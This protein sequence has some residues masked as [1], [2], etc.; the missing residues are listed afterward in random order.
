MQRDK[1]LSG[2]CP[3]T[4]AGYSR[5]QSCPENPTA[6]PGASYG[7]VADRG[8]QVRTFVFDFI[9]FYRVHGSG[10]TDQGATRCDRFLRHDLGHDPGRSKKRRQCYLDRRWHDTNDGAFA[11][12]NLHD[13]RICD[14][15]ATRRVCHCMSPATFL[16]RANG[17]NF[18]QSF[19]GIS[20]ER[21]RY[22]A[23]CRDEERAHLHDTL[24]LSY[25]RWRTS[26]RAS[27]AGSLER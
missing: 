5:E 14:A 15:S 2:C 11:H 12:F 20:D 18:I 22:S 16:R 23:D 9:Q 10:G 21:H 26:S 6:I 25:G 1:L 17:W 8:N 13:A 19:A 24:W 4:T 3:F 7:R 27:Q